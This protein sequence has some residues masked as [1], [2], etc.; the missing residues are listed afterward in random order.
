MSLFDR[1]RS[2]FFTS[3]MVSRRLDRPSPITAQMRLPQRKNEKTCAAAR[4][5]RY[6]GLVVALMLDC[7]LV[8][9][10]DMMPRITAFWGGGQREGGTLLSGKQFCENF[11]M[12]SENS[13]VKCRG[14]H[15]R[16]VEF[17]T[18]VTLSSQRSHSKI[19]RSTVS[20][21]ARTFLTGVCVSLSDLLCFLQPHRQRG[22]AAKQPEFGYDIRW[23]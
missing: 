5:R 19:L 20:S 16:K 10:R 8:I 15:C 14:A 2:T 23:V 22:R 17:F 11:S 4:W 6:R 18:F 9:R 13:L 1:R 7:R 12:T 21:T 3:F